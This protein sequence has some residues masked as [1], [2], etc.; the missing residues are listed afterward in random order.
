MMCF[1]YFKKKRINSFENK[2]YSLMIIT[3]VFITLFAILFYFTTDS[4]IIFLRDFIGKGICVLFVLWYTLFGV[5]LFSLIYTKIKKRDY[6]DLKSIP[7][8]VIIIFVSFFVILS[9]AIIFLPLNYY[10]NGVIKYSYGSAANV[11]YFGAIVIITLLTA[12]TA[13]LSSA[14]I[15]SGL[16][17]I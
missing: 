2:T 3:D 17:N 7:N 6:L 5:Y 16:T 4:H 14:V 10:S 12:P 11:V 13:P 1:V 8:K 15:V 9:L